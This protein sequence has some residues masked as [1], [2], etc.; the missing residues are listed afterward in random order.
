MPKMQKKADLPQKTC[1][2]CGRPFTWR[3]K[4]AGVWDAVK[5]CSQRC[6]NSR[7]KSPS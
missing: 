2:T 6:K 7:A 5:Y 1:M 4:W 3:R